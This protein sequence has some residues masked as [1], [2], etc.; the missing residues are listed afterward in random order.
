MNELS[1]N[2]LMAKGIYLYET[3]DYVT[4]RDYLNRANSNSI[5]YALCLKTLADT[6]LK[7]HAFTLAEYCYTASKTLNVN[8]I[9]SLIEQDNQAKSNEAKLAIKSLSNDLKNSEKT[10]LPTLLAK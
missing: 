6:H 8:Y 1:V 3:E 5:C 10:I 4:A 9:R 2:G 7:L